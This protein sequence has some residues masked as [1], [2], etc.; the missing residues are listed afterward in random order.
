MPLCIISQIETGMPYSKSPRNK[1]QSAAILIN[2]RCDLTCFGPVQSF[3]FLGLGT[4]PYRPSPPTPLVQTFDN[5]DSLHQLLSHS[6][7][8]IIVVVVGSGCRWFLQ[9]SD[10]RPPVLPAMA[11]TMPKTRAKAACKGSAPKKIAVKA[12]STQ[13]A[14]KTK[15]LKQKLI[16][17]VRAAAEVINRRLDRRDSE[18]KRDRCIQAKLGT[19]DQV[20]INTR[21]SQST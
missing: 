11:K 18:E 2:I 15:E 16:R 5:F 3:D 6:H 9:I 21:D 7:I 19:Y 17:E 12:Q 1:S 10:S 14:A 13:P 8:A 20:I 4:T